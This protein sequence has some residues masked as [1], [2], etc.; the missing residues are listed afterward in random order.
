MKLTWIRFSRVIFYILLLALS[1]LG[2]VLVYYASQKYKIGISPDSIQYI[3]TARNLLSGTGFTTYNNSPLVLFPP[4]YSIFLALF[5]LLFQTDP[6]L[7]ANVFNAVLFSIIILL[8][9]FITYQLTQNSLILSILASLT[10]VFSTPLYMVTTMAWSETL[11][12]F[13]I[14]LFFSLL[15][16]FSYKH[17]TII[18]ISFS[19]IS[20]FAILT[21]YIGVVL[22]P[23][24]IITIFLLST[25]KRKD[26]FVFSFIFILISSLPLGIWFIRNFL[27]TGTFTGSRQFSSFSLFENFQSMIITLSKWFLPSEIPVSRFLIALVFLMVGFIIGYFMR[28]FSNIK[29]FFTP[30]EFALLSFILVNIIFLLLSSI[31]SFW[32]LI[33]NR[34]LSPI[35]IPTTILIFTLVGK[36]KGNNKTKLSSYFYLLPTLLISL[37]FTFNQISST[38]YY[39]KNLPSIRLGYNTQMS[40]TNDTLKYLIEN[41]TIVNNCQIYTNNPIA[42]DFIAYFPAETIPSKITLP[43]SSIVVDDITNLYGTWPTQKS[44]LIWFNSDEDPNLYSISELQKIVYI[45]KLVSLKDGSIYYIDKK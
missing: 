22:I 10:I 44:C 27:L 33:D 30:L 9:G 17:Q 40:L 38:M 19:V 7:L 2:F 29:F 42:V 14:I 23:V 28:E 12:I 4:L 35:F 20:A 13:F 26:K 43:I 41:P 1:F 5:G 8:S 39:R 21:R 25:I 45:E 18:F 34:Y 32:Q 16:L 11:F 3:G 37:F 6:L 31:S 36:L 15:Y 24:G